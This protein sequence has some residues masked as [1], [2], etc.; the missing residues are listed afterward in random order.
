MKLEVIVRSDF[1]TITDE[2]GYEI[3]FWTQSEWLE[4]PDLTVDI[5]SWI[6][7]AYEDPEGLLKHHMEH[8]EICKKHEPQW[9]DE[10]R[11][12]VKF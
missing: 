12:I 3:V 5:S 9:K 7:M 4:E 11:I 8:Y 2:E 6:V 10:L 1:I